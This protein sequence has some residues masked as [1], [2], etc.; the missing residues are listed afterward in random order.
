MAGVWGKSFVA[1]LGYSAAVL[2]PDEFSEVASFALF[3]VPGRRV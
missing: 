3:M 2:M 1:L